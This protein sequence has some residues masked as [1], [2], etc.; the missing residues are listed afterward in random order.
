MTLN[1]QIAETIRVLDFIT[2][3]PLLDTRQITLLGHSLGGC[4]AASVTGRDRRVANL[5]LWN[6]VARPLEDLVSIIGTDIYHDCLK[7]QQ[8]LYLGYEL[9]I[10]YIRSW[11]LTHPLKKVRHFAKDVLIIQ[12]TNDQETPPENADLYYQVLQNRPW[13]AVTLKLIEGA[14]HTFSSPVW[15][16][17]TFLSTIGWLNNRIKRQS[18]QGVV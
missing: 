2:E 5:V 7:H 15:E 12:A 8:A 3:H 6:P 18:F 17:Q 4:I 10:E 14:D 1:G 11:S 16:K 13:G 9:G